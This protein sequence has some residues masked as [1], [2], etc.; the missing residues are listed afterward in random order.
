MHDCSQKQYTG[1]TPPTPTR[2]AA[3]KKQ[4]DQEDDNEPQEAQELNV[5]DLIPRTDISGSITDSLISDLNDKNW[6]VS[7][8][9]KTCT[10]LLVIEFLRNIFSHILITIF[11][12]F[13]T[14]PCK[15]WLPF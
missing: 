3:V 13:E 8:C 5:V 15:R 10:S 9:F 6:K 12:R 2:G 4:A 14:R 11:D 7:S 1:Q